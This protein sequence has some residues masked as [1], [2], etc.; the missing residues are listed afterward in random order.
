M[1]VKECVVQPPPCPSHTAALFG[2]EA[3]LCMPPPAL[4][5]PP[6]HPRCHPAGSTPG[7][8]RGGGSV[9]LVVAGD[10]D[11]AVATAEVATATGDLWATKGQEAVGR[12]CAG[13]SR[14]VHAGGEAVTAV[15]LT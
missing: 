10:G 3:P 5:P 15:E 1:G 12:Q 13:D 6:P 8:L 9:S 4:R 2:R 11:A 14:L 7:F